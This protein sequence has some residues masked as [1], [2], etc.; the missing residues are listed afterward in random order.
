MIVHDV[1]ASVAPDA[2]TSSPKG[3]YAINV[4]PTRAQAD[5]YASRCNCCCTVPGIAYTVDSVEELSPERFPT[6]AMFVDQRR[7]AA[8]GLGANNAYK[9]GIR[10]CNQGQ[11]RS[12]N[13]H[14]LSQADNNTLRRAWYRG[15]DVASYAGLEL[16]EAAIAF[17]RHCA[18]F[19]SGT[20]Y[21]QMGFEPFAPNG[22]GETNAG[23]IR[24]LVGDGHKAGVAR[25]QGDQARVTLARESVP[26]LRA[27]LKDVVSADEVF[28][29]GY[30]AA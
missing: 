20:E 19:A 4:F 22:L 10:A 7:K 23:Y 21:G 2:L 9:D 25:R 28:S 8:V 30:K 11:P 14:D 29:V 24:R 18:E 3:T 26:K 15:W 17:A 6:E 27:L 13:P 1:I 12:A 5:E 16:R